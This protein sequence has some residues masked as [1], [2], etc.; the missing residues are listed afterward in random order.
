MPKERGISFFVN[1]SVIILLIFFRLPICYP[2]GDSDGL[3]KISEIY[4]NP[5]EFKKYNPDGEKYSFVKSF[6]TSLNYFHII[7][8]RQRSQPIEKAYED[9][10]DKIGDIMDNLYFDNTDLRVARNLIEK[11]L[12]SNNAL[13]IRATDLVIKACDELIDL[14]SKDYNSWAELYNAKFIVEMESFDKSRFFSLQNEFAEQ[15]KAALEKLLQAALTVTHILISDKPDTAGQMTLLA[16]T[17]AEREKLMERID[18]YFG[19][20]VEQGLR[21]GQTYLKASISAI[22]EVLGDKE[23]KTFDEFN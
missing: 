15:K 13:I 22:N 2:F 4:Q 1:F 14:N 20:D 19:E 7:A 17:Q 18:S 6:I 3:S 23:K 10:V 9:D 8:E 12:R 5:T 16:V 11:H 21:S